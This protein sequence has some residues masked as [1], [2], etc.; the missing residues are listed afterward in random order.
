[1]TTT[2]D[3]SGARQRK[4]AARRAGLAVLTP[5]WRNRTPA[6]ASSGTMPSVWPGTSVILAAVVRVRSGLVELGAKLSPARNRL[7]DISSECVVKGRACQRM[8]PRSMAR[9]SRVP[10]VRL[11]SR[12]GP[13]SARR[14][15]SR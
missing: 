1:M 9:S 13:R 5:R 7:G 3:P 14:R 11:R 2:S 10:I 8:S 12:G 15:W 6:S 4:T